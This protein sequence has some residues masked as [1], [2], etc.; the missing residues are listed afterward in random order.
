MRGIEGKI[1]AIRYARIERIPYFGI[2][3]G[4]QCAV[5]EFARN[6][7][8]LKDAN[9]TEFDS[10]TANP[11]IAMMEEQQSGQRTRRHDA[12]GRLPCVLSPGS[13][14]HQAYTV[15][16]IH[17]RHRHRY[18]L[19]ND[20]RKAFQERG[21]VATGSQPRRHDRRDHGAA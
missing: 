5:V 1:E 16:S 19:N 10:D 21:L 13:L 17:E 14:A 2:C 11:V 9:S 12:I 18:E 3:L 20:Y 8:G 15:S 6:E 4:M 7:L